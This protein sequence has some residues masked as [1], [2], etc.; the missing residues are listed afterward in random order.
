MI[1]PV[2]IHPENSLYFCASLVLDVLKGGS[3]DS[4]SL[5]SQVRELSIQRTK[6]KE[7]S[8]PIY[9]LSLDLLFLLDVIIV[10]KNIVSYVHK[11]S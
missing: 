6:Q 2:D 10:D 5:F 4:S 7:I 8:L 3:L 11:K 1:L 9:L